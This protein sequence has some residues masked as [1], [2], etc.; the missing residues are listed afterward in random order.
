M[1]S[2]LMQK[3]EMKNK[4]TMW[5]EHVKT[6][7]KAKEEINSITHH[8]DFIPTHPLRAETPP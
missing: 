2:I 6:E 3:N 4:Y 8:V 5:E 1:V 7:G